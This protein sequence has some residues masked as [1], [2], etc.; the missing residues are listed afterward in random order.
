M[1]VNGDQ[2]ARTASPVIPLAI[3]P[4]LLQRERSAAMSDH[5]LHCLLAAEKD[6]LERYAR[7]KVNFVG[8]SELIEH[9]RLILVE[10]I[11]ALL[12]YQDTHGA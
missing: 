7:I 1:G 3:P 10:A 8:N 11:A 2:N 5:E 6:A 12:K 4:L 9:A